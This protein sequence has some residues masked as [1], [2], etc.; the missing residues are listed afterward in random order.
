[1]IR[2]ITAILF[3]SA[4]L[5]HTSGATGHTI[6]SG[7]IPAD[8]VRVKIRGTN[9]AEGSPFLD[10][11]FKYGTIAMKSGRVIS[12]VRFRINLVTIETECL[13][14][15][16][17]TAMLSK[18]SVKEISYTDT[19][20]SGTFF[21]KIKTGYPPLEKQTRDH[22]Y[23]ILAEGRCSFL[24]SVEKRV[25]EKANDLNSSISKAYETQNEYYFF[26]NGSVK[27]WRK[28]KEFVV[29]ELADKEEQVSKFILENKTNFRN[30][31]SV[32]ALVNYYNSL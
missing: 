10:E 21:Y 19:T 28:E 23:I 26:S 20:E 25:S 2:S 6:G 9:Y 8:G 11:A 27:R 14:P 22:F 29:A 4:L 16:G 1:M 18:G 32:T 12:G 24:R 30:L 3:S 15:T 5:F 31:E 17:F 7:R 13:F